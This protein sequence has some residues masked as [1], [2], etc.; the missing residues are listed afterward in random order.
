MASSPIRS[1]VH[2]TAAPTELLR[3]ANKV[4]RDCLAVKPGERLL[5]ISDARADG[6][7]A[8]MIAAAG[9]DVGAEVAHVA[10]PWKRPEPHGYLTWEEP[11]DWL[12]SLM[13]AHDAVVDYRTTCLAITAAKQRVLTSGTRILWLSAEYDYLR[14]AVLEEDYGEMERLAQAVV[15]VLAAGKTVRFTCRLGT[16]LRMRLRADRPVGYHTPFVRERGRDDFF[17]TGMWHVAPEE[18][19]VNGTAVFSGNV[20]PLGL[21]SSPIRVEFTDGRIT[22]IQG[23]SATEWRHWLES[24]EDDG[25]FLHSHIGGGLVRQASTYGHDWEDLLIY[26][27]ALV[28]GGSDTYYGGSNRAQGHFDAVVLRATIEVDGRPICVDGEYASD[29]LSAG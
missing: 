2:Y 13:C 14:P 6:N 26:G 28:S 8:G 11:Q 10:M 4:I 1:R 17:P 5:V 22:A 7:L 3:V 16:D 19:S 12:T 21:L 18:S 25:L 15:S 29:L 27:S 23:D 20:H 9:V 24:F